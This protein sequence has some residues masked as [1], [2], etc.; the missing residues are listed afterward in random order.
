[1]EERRRGD[2]GIHEGSARVQQGGLTPYPILKA[3]VIVW[4]EKR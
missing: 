2:P 1:M 3:V 4:I